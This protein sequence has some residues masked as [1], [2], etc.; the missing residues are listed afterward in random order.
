MDGKYL[1]NQIAFKCKKTAYYQSI[2]KQNGL[3]TS[4]RIENI[5]NKFKNIQTNF[6]DKT[7]SFI[8]DT[9][10]EQDIGTI[11]LGYN[12]N[13]QFKSNM[14]AKQNQIFSHY[15]FKQFKEKLETKCTLHDIELIIQEESYTSKSS[16]LDNDILPVYQ[17]N[18]EHEKYEF[19]GQRI[20]R[21][22]YKT[23]DG[24]LINAILLEKVSRNSI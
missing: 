23:S 24:F 20:K 22:L 16:F 1:K 3:T 18:R 19:K 8:I 9:C 17:E 14:G 5:N 15:A 7:V 11:V 6:L 4:H 10:K 13:F 12:N 2:L 21:G